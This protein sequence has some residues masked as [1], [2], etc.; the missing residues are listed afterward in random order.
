[1]NID[2][3]FHVQESE[4]NAA[5]SVS[6]RPNL[7]VTKSTASSS[8]APHL[9][10]ILSVEDRM[11]QSLALAG[12]VLSSLELTAN[13]QEHVAAA[14]AVS[15]PEVTV[16][17]PVFNE[18]KTVCEVIDR[19]LALPISLEVIVVDDGSSDGTRDELQ[20][21]ANHARVRTLLHGV[22]QGK[23]AALRTGISQ[24]RGEFVVI[25]DA[26]LEYDPSNILAVLKPL[27]AG[28]TEA[29]YGSRYLLPAEQ[30][31]SLIH[32]L[33]NWGLTTFSNILA[34]QSLTDMET[35]YKAFR[36]EL[37]QS[38]EIEENRFGFEPEITAKLARTQTQICEVPISYQPRGWKEGKKIGLK[39]LLRTLY[40]IVK[41]N[42]R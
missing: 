32:R 17:I 16:V 42:L 40:C 12:E 29:A 39:D 14:P 22:N 31:R 34:R 38:I 35:C 7:A 10:M 30:D 33:G 9:D 13:G 18:Q 36:R 19:V 26:D 25:Q 1:M 24:A 8:G 28:L 27:Q 23:G 2:K 15:Q 4:T 11:E 6:E 5:I 20:R 41:Y 37:I 21:Y 3:D